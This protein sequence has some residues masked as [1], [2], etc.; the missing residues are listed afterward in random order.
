M[1]GNWGCI[2]CMERLPDDYF[3]WLKSMNVNWV[4]I[5]VALHY[6]N[7]MDST[8]ER[9]YSGVQIPTFTDEFLVKMVR[10]FHSCGFYVYITLA[11]EALEASTSEYPIER[12]QLGDP[13]Y[14]ILENPAIDENFWPWCPDHPLHQI[15]ISE[16][17]RTYTE[18]AVH[19]AKISQSENVEM[20]SLG[21]E[22]ERLFRTRSGEGW[23][24]DFGDELK[25][26]VRS[27]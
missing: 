2:E 11:F 1:G 18:Q 20:F 26:M 24:N 25:A 9:K 12:W 6:S 19:F 5:S 13:R 3:E 14:P 10:K 16:F 21:T 17:W 8:V 7:A 22:T 23:P 27:V 15:F 4:G